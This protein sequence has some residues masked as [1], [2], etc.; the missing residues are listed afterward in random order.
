MLEEKERLST[1][2]STLS[3]LLSSRDLVCLSCH[4]SVS[5]AFRSST[6]NVLPCCH[7]DPRLPH[8]TFLLFSPSRAISSP[9]LPALPPLPPFDPRL[10]TSYRAAVPTRVRLNTLSPLYLIFFSPHVPL[11]GLLRMTF[12]PLTTTQ[13]FR[14]VY[15][16]ILS[17]LRSTSLS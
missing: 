6:S 17:R 13:I 3:P 11:S 8:L 7:V 5:Y 15:Q 10:R 12:A 9:S 14:S 1:R 16:L 2:K 4:L